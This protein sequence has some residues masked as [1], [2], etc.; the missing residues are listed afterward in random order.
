MNTVFSPSEEVKLQLEE[1]NCSW[2]RSNCS[3]G[4][5][6]PHPNLT[7]MTC[8]AF[9][10]DSGATLMAPWNRNAN[11]IRRLRIHV[12]GS[13]ASVTYSHVLSL[14]LRGGTR[15][16]RA[17]SS[18]MCA[19]VAVGY[20][21]THCVSVHIQHAIDDV[22]VLISVILGESS[23]GSYVRTYG[24]RKLTVRTVFHILFISFA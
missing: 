23:Y 12:R 7:K 13:Y 1:S 18:C 22:V 8:A 5:S 4:I 19:A 11:A 2:R 20:A 14:F 9:L 6:G 15:L 21:L 17:C 16:R 3:E 24:I 10:I